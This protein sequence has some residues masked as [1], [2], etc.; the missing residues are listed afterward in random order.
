MRSFEI[1]FGRIAIEGYKL[2]LS[3]LYFI[4][5]YFLQNKKD[6]IGNQKD[7]T[8]KSK[9]LERGWQKTHK[10]GGKSDTRHD[11]GPYNKGG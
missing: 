3:F 11:I 9:T 2:K 7:Y 5:F 8:V 1:F 4:L 10:E 6:F